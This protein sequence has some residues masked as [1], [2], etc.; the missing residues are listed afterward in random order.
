MSFHLLTNELLLVCR[1]FAVYC[2]SVFMFI[3]FLSPLSC[4]LYNTHSTAGTVDIT[5]ILQTGAASAALPCPSVLLGQRAGG[6]VY[7]FIHL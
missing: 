4:L 7:R 6:T 2:S 5:G 3:P 1:E